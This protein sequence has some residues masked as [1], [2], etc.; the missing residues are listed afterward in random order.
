MP[1]I[2]K[3]SSKPGLRRDDSL[4][5]QLLTE[6]FHYKHQLTSLYMVST[7]Y[8]FQLSPNRYHD[9]YISCASKYLAPLSTGLQKFEN[10][11]LCK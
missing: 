11:S 6:N 7:P 3:P 8:K 2:R 10:S 4:L 5:S 9:P 1:P